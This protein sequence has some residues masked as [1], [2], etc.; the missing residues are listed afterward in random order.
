MEPADRVMDLEDWKTIFQTR[1]LTADT[2]PRISM[3]DSPPSLL[4][5][6]GPCGLFF[7]R[8]E[9]IP[10]RVGREVGFSQ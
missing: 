10:L 4:I 5:F 9:A 1:N 2:T 3:Q 7:T 8:Y 6:F